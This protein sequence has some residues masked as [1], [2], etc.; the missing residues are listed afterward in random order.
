MAKAVSMLGSVSRG[1][2]WQMQGPNVAGAAA[3]GMQQVGVRNISPLVIFL[4]VSVKIDPNSWYGAPGPSLNI[5]SKGG[6][7]HH[8]YQRGTRDMGL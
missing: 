8:P 5:H 4:L 6:N 1:G 2:V 3:W 7:I